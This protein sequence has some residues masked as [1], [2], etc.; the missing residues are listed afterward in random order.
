[1]IIKTPAINFTKKLTGLIALLIFTTLPLAATLP[2]KA[3][4]NAGFSLSPASQTVTPNGDL[5]VYLNLDTGGNT[6][7]AWKTAINYSTTAFSSAS[8]MTDP[9]SHFTLNPATDIASGGTIKIARYAL[10]GSSTSGAMAKIT[11]HSNGT[12]GN[13]ALSLAHICSS[14]ADA[15]QCSAVTNVTGTNLLSTITGGTYSVA[16]PVAPAGTTSTTTTKS[17]KKKSSVLGAVA[18]AVAAAV[19]PSTDAAATPTDTTVT[20]TRG[21]VK[22]TVLDQ[23]NK[24]VK[25]AKVT[26]AGVSELTD[27]NG[28]AVIRGLYPGEAKGTIE[29]KGKSQNITVDVQ[30]GT[31]LD[32]PQLASF[33]FKTG[34]NSLIFPVLLAVVGLVVLALLFDLI[35]GSKGGFRAD[36]DHILHHGGDGSTKAASSV[37]Q[38]S[39]KRSE[40]STHD[41][42]DPMT[43]GLIVE[44]NSKGSD[45]EWK[46]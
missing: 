13:T 16:V 18:A 30:S 6:V 5:V 11:L 45:H 17:T 32:S 4:V 43:P 28:Q 41:R 3:A 24:P 40:A 46:Y 42:H 27:G 12:L 26:L 21:T 7:L 9:S 1:M 14:T 39:T 25:G 38:A 2:A 19:S 29:F 36:I 34:G 22:I 33:V 23:K 8:V 31:S 10:T 35:F 37:S 15:S 44:P 20:A